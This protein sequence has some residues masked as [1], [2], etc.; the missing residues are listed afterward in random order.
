MTE[1]IVTKQMEHGKNNEINAVATICGKI[2]P[3]LY[4]TTIFKE[5]G[6]Y[7]KW[8]EVKPFV[9]ASPDGEGDEGQTKRFLFEIK[10]PYESEWKA[11]VHYN[12][13]E[14]YVPQILCQI[15]EFKSLKAIPC[16]DENHETSSGMYYSHRMDIQIRSNIDLREVQLY[17]EETERLVK[18]HFKL[19][20]ERPSD[21]IVFMLSDLDRTFDPQKP[22]VYPVAYGYSSKTLKVETVRNMLDYLRREL[23]SYDINVQVEAFDG[24]FIKLAIDGKDG[25]SLTLL[26]ERKKHWK[27]V[28]KIT[29]NDLAR[30]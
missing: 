24:Q 21:I 6:C 15:G 3:T 27:E 18:E 14:Y 28:C 30:P 16:N 5:V 7:V 22:Y 2:L 13:S 26:Q 20:T 8:K 1:K 10:C 11:P 12:I 17:A 9:V 4:P 25:L 23:V 29:V 19:D